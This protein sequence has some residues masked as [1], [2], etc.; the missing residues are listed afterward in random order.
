M[1]IPQAS[2]VLAQQRVC[3]LL[4]G[5]G[6]ISFSLQVEDLLQQRQPSAVVMAYGVT[7][8]GKTFTMQGAPDKPG[9]VPQALTHIFKVCPQP[10]LLTSVAWRSTFAGSRLVARHSTAAIV[11][12][13]PATPA[14][15]DSPTAVSHPAPAA[16]LLAELHWRHESQPVCDGGKLT[17][18]QTSTLGRCTL[19]HSSI[20]QPV[21][22][23][24]DALPPIPPLIQPPGQEG[25]LQQCAG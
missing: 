24:K 3:L 11:S 5:L 17:Q 15:A 6:S 4:K 20:V 12:V 1:T 21:L 19:V 25:I 8:A 9:L 7:N 2:A 13:H 23:V 18:R 16:A 10:W 14:K 22:A